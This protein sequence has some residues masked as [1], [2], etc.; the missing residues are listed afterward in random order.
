[1]GFPLS[2][3]AAMDDYHWYYFVIGYDDGIC[4]RGLTRYAYTHCH[5]LW[6][7]RICADIDHP[8][9]NLTS[10]FTSHPI[11]PILVASIKHEL[12]NM[13][14]LETPCQVQLDSVADDKNLFYYYI[15]AGPTTRQS[16]HRS[17]FMPIDDPVTFLKM[18]RGSIPVKYIFY[19]IAALPKHFLVLKYASTITFQSSS[20]QVQ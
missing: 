11:S 17:P 1:M 13:Y 16:L 8:F 5:V 7:D 19:L 9:V 10:R 15:G 20:T 2:F 18:T 6:Y 12:I 3:P 4:V 14:H